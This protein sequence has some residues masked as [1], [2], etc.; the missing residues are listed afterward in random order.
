VDSGDG[1]VLE[2]ADVG[3]RRRHPM[4][5]W[6]FLALVL[7]TVAL[8]AY[9]VSR[10]IARGL[11]KLRAGV[12][13]LGEGDLSTR[14]QI[15]G[16]N[17]VADVARAFNAAAA[18]IQRSVEAQR[19]MLASASHELR[20]PL[21]RLRA[22]IELLAAGQRERLPEAERDIEELDALIDD[23]L[24][25]SRLEV[26]PPAPRH[27]PVDLLAIVRE[28]ADRVGAQLA[29][30]APPLQGD[31]RLLRRLVRNLLENATRHGAPPVEVRVQSDVPGNKVT[32]RVV[33]A[34]P[35]VP[36]AER[37]RI[38][39]P[40]YRPDGHAEGRDGGVGLG[41]ALVADIAAHHGG[42]ARCV[43]AETGGSAFEIELPLSGRG[44]S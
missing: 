41:L 19:R 11:E 5:P 42:R 44:G 9:P 20:S 39:E 7:A 35:G 18:K 33:D 8:G 13:G 29:G 23:L 22:A 25:A 34:G 1:G 6:A 10:R 30:Q 31:A 2:L 43:A 38:F 4:G 28:E 17:E 21:G 27:D 37:E 14:V 26:S 36:P 24:L 3:D 40:F 15:E 16:R 32:I 12:A